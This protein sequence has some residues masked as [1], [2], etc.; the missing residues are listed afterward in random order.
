MAVAAAVE[1]AADF[2]VAAVAVGIAAVEVADFTAA[3]LD[4]QRDGLRQ[5]RITGR[6]AAGFREATDPV[7]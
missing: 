2:T 3:A 7:E 5:C 6:R 1:A 4:L